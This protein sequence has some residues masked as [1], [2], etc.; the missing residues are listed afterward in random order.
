VYLTFLW[1]QVHL[2]RYSRKVWYCFFLSLWREF[3][4]VFNEYFRLLGFPEVKA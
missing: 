2:R 4:G 3:T 1:H